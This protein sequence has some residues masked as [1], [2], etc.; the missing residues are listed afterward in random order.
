MTETIK[1]FLVSYIGQY[2][3]IEGAGIAGIDFVWIC[4]FLLL[5]HLC[6]VFFK[7]LKEFFKG[8]FRL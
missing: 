3:Y 2:E 1:E 4:S 6:I 7:M 5:L 8:V